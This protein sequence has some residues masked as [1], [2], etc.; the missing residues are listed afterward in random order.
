MGSPAQLFSVY[1]FDLGD[2][3]GLES[4]QSTMALVVCF[5]RG[6]HGAC[7][8]GM[9]RALFRGYPGS[10][11]VC[12]GCAENS[13]CLAEPAIKAK[14]IGGVCRRPETFR[15]RPHSLVGSSTKGDQISGT[16]PEN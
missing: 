3:G 8:C 12:R 10:A 4:P 7:N 15:P 13:R 6:T 2:S 9:R 14:Q 5:L 1:A 16:H 11:S